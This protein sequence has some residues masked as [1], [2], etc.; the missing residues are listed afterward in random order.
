[1]SRTPLVLAFVA[2]L[3]ASTAASA[4]SVNV[5]WDASVDPTVTGYVVKWGTSAQ[6]YTSAVDVGNRTS[7]TVTGLIPDVKYFFAVTSYA[8]TGLFSSP[9][10][11]VSNDALIVQAGGQLLDQ[12][13]GIFWHNQI[14]GQLE[15]WRLNGTTVVDTRPVSMVASDTHWK[16]AGIGD[17]NGDGF[18]DI[19]WRHDTEGWLAYWLLQYN[20]VVA[21][22]YL[23]IN[24]LADL[25]WQIKG[26]GDIDGDGYDDIIWQHTD[27]SLAAWIMRGATVSSTRFLSIPK[28]GDPR[29]QIAA[30]ADTNG[31]GK[32]DLIWQHPT[33][34][35]LAVWFLQGTNVVGTSLLSI[36]RMTD[37][38]WRIQAV[39]DV[40]GS[41]TPAI[42]WR[43]VTDGWV[44]KWTLRGSV[45]TAT[46][47]F[48]PNKV[49]DLNWKI[50]GSR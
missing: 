35:W 27:G 14:T 29:W 39:G 7:W 13:P 42:V 44:A 8:A 22:G 9:S 30:V 47:F 12:R 18:S 6:T 36:N 38:N 3:L 17:L 2:V 49:E 41:G 31:D 11:E 5:A 40:D 15:T 19:L 1:M 26:V 45:V 25:N 20:Q 33:D 34:G 37:T 32:A 4:Q 50:V 16:V 23:S 24:R 21:T 48:N 10:N 46:Y 28:V 43:H